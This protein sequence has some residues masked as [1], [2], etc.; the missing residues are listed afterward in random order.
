M[1]D[2]EVAQE[3]LRLASGSWEDP[4]CTVA[5]VGGAGINVLRE[6]EAGDG[7]RKVAMD[8]DE[9]SLA[10]SQVGEQVSLGPRLLKGASARG[11]PELGR[12]AADL[13]REE[14]ASALEGEVL[15]LLA[16][17]GR[18]TGTGAAPVV[19][20]VAREAD[21]TVLAFLLWPFP[22]EGVDT[23]ARAGLEAL[24]PRCEAHLVLDNDATRRRTGDHT[25]WEGA[26]RVNELTARAAEGLVNRLAASLPLGLHD[27]L[28]AFW[29]ELPH[30]VSDLLL[31]D[32]A[33]P[34][35]VDALSPV[36][37]DP[38]GFIPLR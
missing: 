35:A 3:F 24:H 16:G 4:H 6:V 9:Y 30:E 14:I 36:S 37:M 1:D 31:R 20:E 26:R 19:A 23:V 7:V 17:L 33:W 34:R 11:D 25:R 22:E 13:Q 12:V 2:W 18:G 28:A 29:E 15:I 38:R 27:V 10:L 8:T 5:G 32:A 21:R